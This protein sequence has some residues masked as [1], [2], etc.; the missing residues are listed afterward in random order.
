LKLLQTDY[1]LTEFVITIKIFNRKQ[2]SMLQFA[3]K[4]HGESPQKK[5]FRRDK[6]IAQAAGMRVI[7]VTARP[8]AVLNVFRNTKAQSTAPARKLAL[9]KT[10]VASSSTW[11]LPFLKHLVHRN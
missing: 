10:F 2:T 7:T 11:M 3:G 1:K 5:T 6:V 4:A 9:N 8:Q